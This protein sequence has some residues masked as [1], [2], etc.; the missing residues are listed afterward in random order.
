MNQQQPPQTIVKWPNGKP[1]LPGGMEPMAKDL[2]DEETDY[3]SDYD[4][5]ASIYS[6]PA[7]SSSSSL[8]NITNV[9]SE[10]EISGMDTNLEMLPSIEQLTKSMQDLTEQDLIP[11]N[12]EN[13]MKSKE[14]C[15]EIQHN[16]NNKDTVNHDNVFKKDAIAIE[17]SHT[18]RDENDANRDI[19]NTQLVV[20]ENTVLDLLLALKC[21]NN[22][23]LNKI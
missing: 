23:K 15:K 11:F 4:M 6:S 14:N 18:E 10:Q 19:A 8:Q 16:K 12:P 7:G 1:P 2:V 13:I 9:V 17:A 21:T 22:K 3:A 20:S 5:E